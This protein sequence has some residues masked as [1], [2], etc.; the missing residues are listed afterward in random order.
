VIH[1]YNKRT[2]HQVTIQQEDVSK[3]A[4][5]RCPGRYRTQNSV[6]IQRST[7]CTQRIKYNEQFTKEKQINRTHPTVNE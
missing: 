5:L 1:K 3:N 7:Y 2:S 4:Y 6:K